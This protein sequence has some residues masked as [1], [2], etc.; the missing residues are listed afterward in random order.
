MRIAAR[1]CIR[2][3]A[4]EF[5]LED[6]SYDHLEDLI[7]DDDLDESLLI[8]VSCNRDGT[9]LYSPTGI[10]TIGIKALNRYRDRYL[11]TQ[12]QEILVADDPASPLVQTEA[13]GYHEL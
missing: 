6:F 9:N 1:R 12:R 7:G 2:I 8:D 13:H 3:A 5:T 11:E 10:L 4:K